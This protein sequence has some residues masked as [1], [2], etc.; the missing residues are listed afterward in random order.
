ML[1]EPPVVLEL[2]VPATVPPVALPLPSEKG[3]EEV[4]TC[5]VLSAVV[6]IVIE[7]ISPGRAVVLKIYCAVLLLFIWILF[8]LPGY[9]KALPEIP[10]A[11]QVVQAY[12]PLPLKL[13]LVMVMVCVVDFSTV[14]PVMVFSMLPYLIKTVV[15]PC[16][17][18][19]SFV[20]PSSHWQ[21][22]VGMVIVEPSVYVA[23]TVRPAGL[24]FSPA[25]YFVLVG[26]PLIVIAEIALTETVAVALIE[27]FFVL[28]AVIV[29]VPAEMPVTMP[30]STDAILLFDDDQVTAL[31]APVGYA[32][33]VSLVVEFAARVVDVGEIDREVTSMSDDPPCP[34]LR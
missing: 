32:V 12:P 13:S 11:D 21:S 2:T 22:L 16:E 10:P 28:V 27:G 6:L 30:L 33:T 8:A 34:P 17:S 7:T 19:A 25:M 9:I 20:V 24:N 29:A 3:V 1:S 26:V 4:K 18:V 23:V 14:I 15:V 5:H 31:L